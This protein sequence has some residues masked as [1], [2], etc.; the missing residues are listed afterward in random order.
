M[1]RKRYIIKKLVY[2][3]NT[4]ELEDM[5]PGGETVYI[6]LIDDINDSQ[7]IGFVKKNNG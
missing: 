6:E 4:R 3:K 7:E 2:A 5:F 1:E